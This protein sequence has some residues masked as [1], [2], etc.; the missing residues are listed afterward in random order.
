MPRG[1]RKDQGSCDLMALAERKL[2]VGAFF[3]I[4]LRSL[5]FFCDSGVFILI[6]PSKGFN[7]LF[8]ASH[9][10]AGNPAFAAVIIRGLLNHEGLGGKYKVFREQP[11]VVLFF[12]PHRGKFLTHGAFNPK[13]TAEAA[14]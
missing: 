11:F 4:A 12:L 7:K 3:F 8:L 13:I 5:I 14:M 2:P 1:R 10:L 9:S 6:T